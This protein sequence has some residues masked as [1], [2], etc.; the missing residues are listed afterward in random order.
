MM[1]ISPPC[2]QATSLFTV[3]KAGQVA[4]PVGICEMSSTII[5]SPNLSFE[6]MWMLGRPRAPGGTT[7]EL[8]A[9]MK[10]F[11]PFAE[12]RLDSSNGKVK[13]AWIRTMYKV[14]ADSIFQALVIHITVGW[15]ILME[16]VPIATHEVSALPLLCET[17]GHGAH[18]LNERERMRNE[19]CVF[20]SHNRDTT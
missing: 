7:F 17:V 1:S 2:G 16:I 15:V 10:N 19:D 11:F 9:C 6:E 4:Q 20:G 13:R 14:S 8:S 3:Q 5:E 12:T 18:A